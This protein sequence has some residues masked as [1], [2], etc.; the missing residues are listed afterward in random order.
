MRKYELMMI[1]NPELT[2]DDKTNLVEQIEKELA[3]TGATIATK[4]DLGVKDLAYKMRSSLTGNYLLY[5]LDGADGV[6]FFEVTKSFNIR[7]DIWRFMFVK[8]ED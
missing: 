2:Q 6:S 3:D 4:E 8:L 7:K 5:T 1:I